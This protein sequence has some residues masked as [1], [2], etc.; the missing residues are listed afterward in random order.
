MICDLKDASLVTDDQTWNTFTINATKFDPSKNTVFERD[1]KT[2][3]MPA[4]YNPTSFATHPYRQPGE[5]QSLGRLHPTSAYKSLVEQTKIHFADVPMKAPS[6]SPSLASL[7][8]SASV[9]KA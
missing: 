4:D 6:R 3:I 1:G 7:G 2:V 5:N 8:S 9:D